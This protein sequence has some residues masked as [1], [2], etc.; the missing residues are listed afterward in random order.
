MKFGKIISYKLKRVIPMAAIAGATLAPV[1]CLSFD[2]PTP[3]PKH[4]DTIYT[5]G[6]YYWDEINP[7]NRV[8]DSADSTV[9]DHVIL[10]NDGVSWGGMSKSRGRPAS[11]R[12]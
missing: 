3:T 11:V 5:W 12:P 4:H 1:S 6:K 8:A 9:V 2:D 10:Q 7:I